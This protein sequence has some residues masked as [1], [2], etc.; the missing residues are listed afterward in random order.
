M[1]Y[2]MDASDTAS[3]GLSGRQRDHLSYHSTPR[4][5]AQQVMLQRRVCVFIKRPEGFETIVLGHDSQWLCQ[6]WNK[7]GVEKIKEFQVHHQFLSGMHTLLFS[8][9]L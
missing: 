3:G 8:F 9:W 2:A 6:R 5:A 1:S 4:H 7:W